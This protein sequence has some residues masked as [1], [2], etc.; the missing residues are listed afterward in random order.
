MQSVGLRYFTVYGPK[1]RPDM[2]F[3]R[4]IDCLLA[5]EPFPIYGDGEQVRDVTFIADAVAATILG[6]EKGGGY[7]YNVAGGASV[8]VLG[9]ISELE[10]ITGKPLLIEMFPAA[11]GDVRGVIAET[12]ALQELGWRAKAKFRDGLSLQWEASQSRAEDGIV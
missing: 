6:L 1:Q 2:A 7:L 11:R 5:D 4:M 8:S 10:W 12:Q 3:Q 9:A